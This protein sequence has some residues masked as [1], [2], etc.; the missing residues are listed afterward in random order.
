MTYADFLL[1]IVLVSTIRILSIEYIVM[2]TLFDHKNL[3][4]VGRRYP[5]SGIDMCRIQLVVLHF[6]LRD[7]IVVDV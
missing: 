5:F 6:F 1:R 4:I 3:S 7:Y 2:F